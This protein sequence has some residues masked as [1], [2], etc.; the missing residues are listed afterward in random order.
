MQWIKE[1]ELVYSVD[2]LRILSSTRG[3][4]MSNFEVLDAR[5]ASALKKSSVIHISKEESV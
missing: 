5:I 4:P 3:I 2:E 1:V